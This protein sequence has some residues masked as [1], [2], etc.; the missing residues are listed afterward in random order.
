MTEKKLTGYASVDKPWLKYYS[1][2]AIHAELP[3]T[4]IFDY[5][6]KNN[7][8][9]PQDI[10]F[11]FY[12][13]KITYKKLFAEIEKTTKAFAALGV[14]CGD[15]VA[16]CMPAVPE[17][18]YAILALNRLG[19]NAN[20]LN[21]TFSEAQLTDRIRESD[22]KVLLVLNELYGQ[23]EKAI[24]A[25]GIKTVIACPAVNSFGMVAK[26]VRHIKKIPGTVDWNNFIRK[27]AKVAYK[28]AKYKPDRPAIMVYSS[29]TT[30]A[31]K[32]IQLTNDGI[33]ATIRQYECAGFNLKRQDRYLA[34]IP[35]WFST[36][37]SVTMLVPLCLGITLIL[38]PVYD[39]ALIAKDIIKYKPN[40]LISAMGLFEYL[41]RN[42]P[43]ADAYREFKYAAVGGEYVAPRV[44]EEYNR[45]L[46]GNGCVEGLHKG[47]G[48]CECGGTVTFSTSGCNI[49]G[50]SGIPM[51]AV[52]VAAFDL[53]SDTEL[54]Y[55]ERG[56]I[57]VLTPCRMKE[58]YKRP[59]A[60]AAYLRKDK[61]GNVWACTGDMG[62]V[63][64]D[65]NVYVSGR[66]S[67]SYRN[68]Q[69]ETI[70]LFD[71]ERA[72]LEAGAVRQCKVV[73]SE[74][75]GKL[76]HVAHVVLYCEQDTVCNILK[77]VMEVCR[78]K[79]AE[80]HMPHLF[81]IY[82]DALPV[83]PSGKLDV[84]EMKSNI[85]DLIRIK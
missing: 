13:K 29:G 32:G 27:G 11:L 9:H 39:F 61:H 58:Y 35:I 83:A 69:G 18:F 37:I 63:S 25:A 64:E 80:N 23:M 70:Y 74:I 10:A 75:N 24:P 26:I 1:D 20:M 77:K 49:V 44:E 67:D 12:G 41:K 7:K 48:M 36:G 55:G 76:V 38:E 6:Y 78:T 68:T 57:R 71:I 72:I 81:K 73:S 28:P 84:P 2:E 16:I 34:Q 15:N 4:I 5:I 8:D 30:G 52:T 47:Y 40:F 33:A 54:P 62:F 51:P 85:T 56:E 66:I 3:K 53:N 19:A 65:G 21:P 79:L 22:A 50:S 17:A 46:K 60:T 42:Y 59:D 82:D 43:Q 45:W 14:G 31:S